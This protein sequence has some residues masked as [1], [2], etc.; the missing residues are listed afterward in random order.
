M[1][2]SSG[3]KGPKVSS[4]SL[5]FCTPG[6]PERTAELKAQLDV[7]TVARTRRESKPS[8]LHSHLPF[9]N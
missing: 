5:G 9:R 2:A 1:L 3:V 6:T 7:K 4:E 8:A